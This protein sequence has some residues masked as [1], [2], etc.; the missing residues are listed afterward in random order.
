MLTILQVNKDITITLR[1]QNEIFHK[2]MK[3]RREQ[4]QETTMRIRLL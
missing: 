4:R 3:D 2:L 1:G